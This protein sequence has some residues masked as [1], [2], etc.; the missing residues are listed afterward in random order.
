M[1]GPNL[2]PGASLHE[3]QFGLSR[4]IELFAVPEGLVHP[5]MIH[6]RAD[7]TEEAHSYVMTAEMARHLAGMF[8]T[9]ANEAE[10]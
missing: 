4:R 2:R 8:T 9:T 7:G 1:N 5:R 10:A 6:D 3:V